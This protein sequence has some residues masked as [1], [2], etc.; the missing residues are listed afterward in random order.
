MPDLRPVIGI[1]A[2]F[3]VVYLFLFQGV[4]N[5][6]EDSFKSIQPD[7]PAYSLPITPE[8]LSFIIVFGLAAIFALKLIEQ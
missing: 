2:F 5:I 4:D 3:L 1:I 6:I 7:N 8:L